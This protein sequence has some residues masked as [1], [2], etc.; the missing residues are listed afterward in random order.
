MARR[1]VEQATGLVEVRRDRVNE[2]LYEGQSLVASRAGGGLLLGERSVTRTLI[3]WAQKA[4]QLAS[5][6]VP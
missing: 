1:T 4:T 3:N 5:W 6:R 2:A